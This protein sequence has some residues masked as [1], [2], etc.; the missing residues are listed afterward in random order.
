MPI[1]CPQC[2]KEN[3]EDAGRC[4]GCGADL[5]PGATPAPAA[6]G[7]KR[8]KSRAAAGIAAWAYRGAIA[9]LLVALIVAQAKLWR[10]RGDLRAAQGDLE[11]ARVT[12]E[13]AVTG[14][15][16]LLP[17]MHLVPADGQPVR[18]GKKLAQCLV[19]EV[20][21]AGSQVTVRISNPSSVATQPFVRVVL[22][23]AYG[24]QVGDGTVVEFRSRSF[25]TA[26]AKTLGE[27]VRMPN[28]RPRYFL[29]TDRP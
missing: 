21:F 7:P 8:G 10:A 3:A 14:G 29:I 18:L 15:G 24:H 4:A 2:S 26:E 5:M 6:A 20:T 25:A 16:G 23:N 1:T 28:P 17:E 13:Q 9:L 22:F 11:H 19:E 27:R 12:I